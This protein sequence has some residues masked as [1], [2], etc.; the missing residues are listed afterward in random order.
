[1]FT[2]LCCNKV[3]TTPTTGTGSGSTE[4]PFQIWGLFIINY[5]S[6][7]CST[8]TYIEKQRK[9]HF[10]QAEGTLSSDVAYPCFHGKRDY[11]YTN[12]GRAEYLVRFRLPADSTSS[13][14]KLTR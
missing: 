6:A 3:D 4:Q 13:S 1:M 12:H 11:Q 8:W 9:R 10:G 14:L 5:P 7:L 2:Q